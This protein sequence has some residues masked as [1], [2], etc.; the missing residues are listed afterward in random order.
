MSFTHSHLRITPELNSLPEVPRDVASTSRERHR[1]ILLTKG[2][3]AEQSGKIERSDIRK[4]FAATEIVAE[5]EPSV[6]IR[7]WLRNTIA[8][9]AAP[10]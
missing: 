3:I 6:P 7:K 10:G 4:Y 8:I 5:K 1:L 9:A 2:A